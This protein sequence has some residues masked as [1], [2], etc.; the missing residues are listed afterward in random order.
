M[1]GPGELVH[2]VAAREA[3]HALHETFVP[4]DHAIVGIV[5]ALERA[6][7]QPPA[8][9]P[10]ADATTPADAPRSS[11]HEDRP[12][13]RHGRL[14][15][16]ARDLRGPQAAA[17]RHPGS[18]PAAPTATTSSRSTPSA[19]APARPSSCST[20]APPPARSPA[21][22]GGPLRTIVVGIIDHLDDD[23]TWK[24][25]TIHRGA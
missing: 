21:C 9:D 7:D 6:P 24:D 14:H 12:R 18:P 1:A 22:P 15:H 11:P 25:E 3:A 8:A 13:R 10:K 17:L 4:V 2:Y 23:G 19:P 20:K 5:D 16:P